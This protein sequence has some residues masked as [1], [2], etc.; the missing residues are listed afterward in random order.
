MEKYIN[1]PASGYNSLMP[2]HT[3][4]KV[5]V[6]MRIKDKITLS[7]FSVCQILAG[8]KLMEMTHLVKFRS[9]L[10]ATAPYDVLRTAGKLFEAWTAPQKAT[11]DGIGP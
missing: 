2:E 9:S 7:A 10:L 1:I 11:P 6:M 3:T 4:I 5:D 8:L